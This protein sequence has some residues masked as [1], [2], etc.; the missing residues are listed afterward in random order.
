MFISTSIHFINAL[1]FWRLQCLW[2]VL[3]TC[4]LFQLFLATQMRLHHVIFS[5][6]LD[7]CI[8]SR[9]SCITRKKAKIKWK[10]HQV[11]CTLLTFCGYI[12]LMIHD[13]ICDDKC[14]HDKMQAHHTRSLTLRKLLEVFMYATQV[15]FNINDDV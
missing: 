13:T 6:S 1:L 10:G 11:G 8:A 9:A 12:N 5:F 14:I 3:P 2:V 15:S 4:L 7:V